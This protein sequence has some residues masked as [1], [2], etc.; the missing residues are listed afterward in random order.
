MGLATLL[1]IQ[2]CASNNQ[3]R[4]SAPSSKLRSPECAVRG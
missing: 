2:N 1:R 3:R 4:I